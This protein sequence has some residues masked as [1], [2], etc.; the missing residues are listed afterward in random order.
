MDVLRDHGLRIFLALLVPV[1]IGRENKCCKSLLDRGHHT[2]SNN[3]SKPG[4]KDTMK[5]KEESGGPRGHGISAQV[6]FKSDPST[7][8]NS[9]SAIPYLNWLCHSQKGA[10]PRPHDTWG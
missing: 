3:D 4:S 6:S 8:P 5:G 9:P 7:W 1:E 10:R 2:S